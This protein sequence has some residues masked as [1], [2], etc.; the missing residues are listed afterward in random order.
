MRLGV[1]GEYYLISRSLGLTIGGAIGI[2]LFLCRAL[3]VTLYSFGLTEVLSMIWPHAQLGPIP[4]QPIAAGLIVVV[5][6][7]S[8]KSAAIALRSQIPLLILV[9]VS[10]LALAV[11]VFTGPLKQPVPFK[12][13][14]GAD[15]SV[16]FWVVFAVFFPAMTGLAA[17]IGMSGDLKDPQ[18]SIPR[19]TLLAVATGTLVYMT[20][21]ILLAIT[22]RVTYRELADIST[23]TPP[24]WNRIAF[25][26]G[27]LVF[28]GMCAAILSSAFGS[29]LAGPRVLQALARDGLA[30]KFL[31]RATKS[32][33]PMLA[34][35]AAGG[36]ALLAVL[37]GDLNAVAE[38][39][40]I[41]FL[42]LYLS[43]NLVCAVET[44]VNNP[45]FRP[46]LRV[47]WPISLLGA[48]A[49]LAV[50]FLINHWACLAAIT[51]ELLVWL[52]LRRKGLETSWGDVRAGFWG[53]M[54]RLALQRLEQLRHDPRNWRPNVLLFANEIE[55]R[56]DLVRLASSFHQNRGILTVCDVLTGRARQDMPEVQQRQE[57]I[58]AFCEREGIVAFSEVDI[59]D[60]LD[61]GMI[62]IIQAHGIGGLRANTIVFG[63]PSTP[64]RQEQ[65][66]RLLP[67][68]DH[69]GKATLLLRPGATALQRRRKI[70]VWWRGLQNNGDLMLL[71]AHLLRCSPDWR[72]ARI[73]LRTILSNPT[74][75]PELETSMQ[76]LIQSVRIDAEYEVIVKPED[77]TVM[78]TMHTAGRDADLAF[79]GL[80]TPKPGGEA[81]Y[82]QRLESFT[83]KLPTTVL[84]RNAG[85]FAGQLIE[86]N[87]RA[88]PAETQG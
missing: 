5:T 68:L 39:V 14:E 21:P 85:P 10:I 86:S 69:L 29:A 38:L 34:S 81:E 11:G 36:I 58:E 64:S 3:S 33:Q 71:L 63:W 4:M 35:L 40:T 88:A 55:D 78:Q 28:P 54:A 74:S 53:T 1:G 52:I 16:G 27:V 73:C 60:D 84:V 45:S 18:R 47:P 8:G 57:R 7:I 23:G 61:S 67:T 51:L 9:T 50:M 20:I 30:P 42:T 59:V 79:V 46:T 70:D 19:G 65:I 72:G 37:L 66:L 82:A 83:A 12:S 62:D 49:I 80:M 15:I 22:G 25:L 44:W 41:F 32:G 13:V 2:P 6:L 75:R 31:A 26:G 43:I 56:A 76:R 77:E 48:V 24:V 87:R 17:G